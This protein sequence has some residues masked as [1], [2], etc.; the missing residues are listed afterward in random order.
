MY[1]GNNQPRTPNGATDLLS[2]DPPPSLSFPPHLGTIYDD[3]DEDNESE[4]PPRSP[5]SSRHGDNSEIFKRLDSFEAKLE[6]ELNDLEALGVTRPDPDGKGERPVSSSPSTVTTA[7]SSSSSSSKSSKKNSSFG[8]VPSSSTPPS[9]E[10][11]KSI[12]LKEY[13]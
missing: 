10:K 7:S 6:S 1:F 13:F 2:N 5:M 4:L 11:R 9:L 12:C 3:D 8:R